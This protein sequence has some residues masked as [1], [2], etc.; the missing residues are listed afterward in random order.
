MR[1]L[2]VL[3]VLPAVASLCVAEIVR[4]GFAAPLA[5]GVS[6]WAA[7]CRVG[8]NSEQDVMG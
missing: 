3:L 5:Y 6:R 7:A 1:R 2:R 8:P 4:R